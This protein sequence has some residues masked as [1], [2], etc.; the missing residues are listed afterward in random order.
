[1]SRTTTPTDI[2]RLAAMIEEENGLLACVHCG[3]CLS[4]CP[5]YL[6]L[7]DEAD[8]PRGR[9][10][11][12]R[13]VGE[14]RLD[15]AT[16]AFQT[17]IDRCLGCRACEPVCPSG[18]SYGH[19]LEE[20]RA[21][22]IEARPLPLATRML[23]S[24]F[25]SRKASRLAMLGGRIV[26]R[27]GLA[28][29]LSRRAPSRTLRTAFAML[30]ATKPGWRSR[31]SG[32]T[33]AGRAPQNTAGSPV[34]FRDPT[35]IQGEPRQRLVNLDGC[36]QQGL[37]GRVNDATRRVLEAND[38]HLAEWDA[39]CCGALHAHA[40]ALGDA[41][42]R[43]RENI[44]AWEDADRPGVVVNAA[45]CGAA[46]KAYGE[47]LS[48]D[49]DWAERAHTF[50]RSVRDVSEWLAEMGP[51]T[52]APIAAQI[53]YDPPCHLLHAQG[54]SDPVD[55]LFEA[56]PGLERRAVQ[57]ASECCGGAGIYAMTHPELG[58]EI[59]RD[60]IANLRATGARICATGNPGCMMQIG[61][62]LIEAGAE[63]E[64][65]HPVELLDESYRRA[66]FYGR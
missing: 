33:R 34:V 3:F 66:G 50:S 14:G 56:I 45:G 58:G 10:H 27:L 54:V 52:G 18:V 51:R 53:A 43:A 6:R 1:M 13:A 12:M 22:A 16:D 35:R 38:Y 5:T 32:A 7:G 8:S 20:A 23:L 29:L 42:T 62:G 15:P 11:L 55:R 19:L 60:K 57:N 47:L 17:H 30:A 48:G 59:G 64:V 46:M 9:L 49:P 63:M 37:L 24:V 40:G 41:R 21:V 36:V 4:A 31:L 26:R 65:A 2:T 44:R 39:G 28:G 25:G 61:A